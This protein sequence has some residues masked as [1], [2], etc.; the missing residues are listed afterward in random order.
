[1]SV[2]PTCSPN[3][4]SLFSAFLF[5]PVQVLCLGTNHLSAAEIKLHQL[6]GVLLLVWSQARSTNC[7]LK[8]AL[9]V[10]SPLELQSLR[11]FMVR[12]HTSLK[13]C[14][15]SNTFLSFLF[16]IPERKYLSL[17]LNELRDMLLT[18]PQ[19]QFFLFFFKSQLNLYTCYKRKHHQKA[20]NL[21][22]LLDF[23][24]MLHEWDCW[25]LSSRWG[26]V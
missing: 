3:K 22:S 2:G 7:W 21:R 1:M 18:S 19:F 10:G 6:Q 12:I 17:F 25:S 4:I 23:L 8:V 26:V 9:I 15:S 13:M 14:T 16:W 20:I 11:G 24:V 5:V